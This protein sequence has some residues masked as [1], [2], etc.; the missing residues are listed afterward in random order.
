MSDKPTPAPKPAPGR[1]P[2]ERMTDLA[3]RVVNVPKAE[4][5]KRERRTRKA[6]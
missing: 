5:V 3:R 6:K 4:A 2:L 1:S